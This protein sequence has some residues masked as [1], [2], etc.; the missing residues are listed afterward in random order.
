[1][2]QFCYVSLKQPIVRLA[3]LLHTKRFELSKIVSR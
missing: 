1:M 2:K 3:K